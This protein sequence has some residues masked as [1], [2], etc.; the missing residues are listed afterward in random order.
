MR[1]KVFQWVNDKF[2]EIH[3]SD[4]FNFKEEVVPDKEGKMVRQINVFIK[5]RTGIKKDWLDPEVFK[6][7][8]K[9]L[10]DIFNP[11]LV[12]RVISSEGNELRYSGHESDGVFKGV[13]GRVYQYQLSILAWTKP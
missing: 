11:V 4:V 13:E 2:G 10:K 7:W 9:E 12:F 3:P 1:E 6:V 8:V 5:K